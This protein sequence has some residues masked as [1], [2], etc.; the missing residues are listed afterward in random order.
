MGNS[1]RNFTSAIVFIIAGVGFMAMALY[2]YSM[3]LKCLFGVI[4]VIGVIDLIGGIWRFCIYIKAR[5]EEG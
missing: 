2:Q 4:G 1:E 5:K 3:I